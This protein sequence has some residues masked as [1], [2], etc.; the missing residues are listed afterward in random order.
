[1]LRIPENLHDKLGVE[2]EFF[3]QSLSTLF[4]RSTDYEII[5]NF[6]IGGTHYLFIYF[7]ILFALI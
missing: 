4:H 5:W 1:M 3:S 6:T 2:K 7:S